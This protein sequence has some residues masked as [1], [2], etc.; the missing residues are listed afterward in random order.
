[1]KKLD[2]EMM[3]MD[4]KGLEA[5]AARAKAIRED[6]GGSVAA[7]G[8]PALRQLFIEP[9]DYEI[10]P[11]WEEVRRND[12]DHFARE[13]LMA[14]LGRFLPAEIAHRQTES[15]KGDPG[16]ILA[17]LTERCRS[18]P[19]MA[20]QLLIE[21]AV[22]GLVAAG[23]P[24]SDTEKMVERALTVLGQSKEGSDSIWSRFYQHA[25]YH[26]WSYFL[27]HGPGWVYRLVSWI[28]SSRND[29][30]SSLYVG[31]SA[32]DRGEMILFEHR[33][34]VG[35]YA[36]YPGRS[37]ATVWTNYVGG[38][39]NDRTSSILA[40][41]RFD[42]EKEVAVAL[43]SLG[44][45]GRVSEYAA[46]VPRIS[47]RG[48]PIIT[49]DMWPSFSPSRRFV[50]IRIPVRV[51][52]PNWWDYDAEIR[53]WIYLYVNGAGNLGGYVDWYGCWVESGI[54]SGSIADRIM[55]ALP[56]TIGTLNT[57]LANSISLVAAL[58]GPLERQY[59]LP[60]T[61]AATGNTEDDVTIVLVRR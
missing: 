17:M 53:Y 56:D 30:I 1:M 33:G 55:D 15:E 45:G 26:G 6:Y 50:Y 2:F 37:G 28:G 21:D 11:T 39:I 47:L 59:F 13:N 3:L 42:P 14:D 10:R 36:R 38:F 31:T 22:N 8:Q 24:D 20:N 5:L 34:F 43:G 16:E 57:E 27:N 19:S 60:G 52:V 9:R 40:V 12:D 25:N 23:E 41:R 48:S 4:P 32:G 58:V 18:D 54:K 51:D 49:W 7:E 29:A 46:G 61:A 44:L 35:R